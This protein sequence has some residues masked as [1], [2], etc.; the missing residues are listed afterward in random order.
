VRREK[1][2]P[3]LSELEAWLRSERSKLSRSSSV[4]TPINY[5]L[6]RWSAFA[7]FTEDGRICLTNN[8][9]LLRF[10]KLAT[11]H[12]AALEQS[13]FAD[14]DTP[15][16]KEGEPLHRSCSDEEAMRAS[17]GQQ[18]VDYA[19]A[20]GLDLDRDAYA[21]RERHALVADLEAAPAHG[22]DDRKTLPP[23][24]IASNN[25]EDPGPYRR[26]GR[27]RKCIDGCGWPR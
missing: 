15:T 19:L 22:D 1:S 14:S 3:L 26:F 4:L 10:T 27:S 6:K 23:G 18:I 13:Q 25:P 8:A 20:V 21:G 16:T 7:R 17:G 24:A 9:A 2:K 12:R 11:H 5:M